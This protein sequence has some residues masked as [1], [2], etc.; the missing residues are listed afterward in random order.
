MRV[1]NKFG[2]KVVKKVCLLMA[3][4]VGIGCVVPAY[5]TTKQDAEDKIDKLED[6]KK[7]LEEYVDSLESLKSDTEAYIAELDTKITIIRWS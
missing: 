5:A 7:E 3:L 2:K 4:V 6:D 1:H